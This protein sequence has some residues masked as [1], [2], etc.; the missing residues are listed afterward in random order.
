MPR[1][2]WSLPGRSSC[3]RRILTLARRPS[4]RRIFLALLAVSLTTPFLLSGPSSSARPGHLTLTNRFAPSGTVSVDP[5]ASAKGLAATRKL[6]AP[7]TGGSSG[8]P[9]VSATNV[10]ADQECTN[11][12]AAGYL[13]RGE[14][15]NETAVA[16]N[17][18]NARNVLISQN[19]YREGD[20]HCG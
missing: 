10:R 4:M 13:G 12:S 7:S 5:L 6:A 3:P 1:R 15:Q 18:S 19:D 16:V 8:C 20:G 17:P 11:Q 14:S 2:R 9:D